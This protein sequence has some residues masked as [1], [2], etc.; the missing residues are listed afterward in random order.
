[1]TVA[2]VGREVDRL[3]VLTVC[4][5]EN[6]TETLRDHVRVQLRAETVALTVLAG[7]I[8]RAAGADHVDDLLLLRE[9]LQGDVYG[10]AD[11]AAEHDRLV[12]RDELGCA[13]NSDVGLRL[14]VGDFVRDL[15]AEQALLAGE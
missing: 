7:R 15:L 5:D 9:L 2:V 6:G 4:L 8:V 10:A 11:A 14:G 3:P 13:L 12:L 1:M